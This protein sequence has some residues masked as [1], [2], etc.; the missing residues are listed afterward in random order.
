MSGM[1][2]PLGAKLRNSTADCTVVD[3]NSVLSVKM[4]AIRRVHDA[5]FIGSV[6][7]TVDELA[8]YNLKT[9]WSCINAEC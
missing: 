8:K 1:S 6:T 3:Q 9:L 4:Q 5:G 2:E 7:S